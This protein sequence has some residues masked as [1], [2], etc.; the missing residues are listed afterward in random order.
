MA[1]ITTKVV[2]AVSFVAAT[3]GGAGVAEY[4]AHQAEKQATTPR[5]SGEPDQTAH[6]PDWST[7]W[8]AVQKITRD[9]DWDGAAVPSF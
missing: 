8:F 2:I 7:E 1:F 4:Y 3:G 9:R 6:G 5:M